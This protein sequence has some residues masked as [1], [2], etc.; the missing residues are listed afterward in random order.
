MS[1]SECPVGEAPIQAMALGQHDRRAACSGSGQPGALT[2][3][4]LR[5]VAGSD[6]NRKIHQP[7]VLKRPATGRT[8]TVRRRLRPLERAVGQYRAWTRTAVLDIPDRV[9]VWIKVVGG[10]D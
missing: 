9:I 4:F 3:Y 6:T 7:Q 5:A 10:I 8:V 2:A 1:L